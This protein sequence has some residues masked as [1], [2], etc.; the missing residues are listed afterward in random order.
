VCSSDLSG[1]ATA[2][3]TAEALCE[4]MDIVGKVADLLGDVAHASQEQAGGISQVN[5]G[6]RQIDAITQQNTATAEETASAAGE[7]SSEAERLQ[8]LLA[9]FKLKQ[10]PEQ[11]PENHAAARARSAPAPEQRQPREGWGAPAVSAPRES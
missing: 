4:I 10:I 9:R 8:R 5:D 2:Q 6:L 11:A 3:Q 1:A 7:L